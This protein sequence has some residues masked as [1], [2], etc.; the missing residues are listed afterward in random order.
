MKSPTKQGQED[1]R[2]YRDLV[3][4][5]HFTGVGA[6][7]YLHPDANLADVA[8]ELYSDEEPSEWDAYRD[9]FISECERIWELTYG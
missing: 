4:P 1:A 3:K 9:G 5:S 2:H 7:H 8:A 6:D